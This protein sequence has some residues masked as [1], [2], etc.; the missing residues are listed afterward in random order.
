MS[1]DFLQIIL[2]Q[3]DRVFGENVTKEELS[4]SDRGEWP[5]NLWTSIEEA[6]L[7]HAMVAEAQA[8]IGLSW[9]DA[10]ALI[11]R[12][13][14]WALPLPLPETI[15]AN[16]LWCMSG[17]EAL[18]GPVA[19]GPVLHQDRIT[20]DK[21]PEGVVLQGTMH[22][23]PWLS[24]VRHLLVLAADD[25][26]EHRLCLLQAQQIAALGRRRNLACEPRENVCLDGIAVTPQNTRP[27]FA[28][29]VAPGLQPYLAAIRAQQIVGGLERSLE[30]ALNY[31]NERVQFG[32][33]IAKFQAIQHMLAVAAGQVAAATAAADALSEAPSLDDAWF[34]IA[35]AKA[36]CSEA[37]GTVAAICHQVHGAMGFTQEHPLHFTTRRLWSWRD[38]GG[39]ET[40]WQERIG[41]VVCAGGSEL[42]W[43]AIVNASAGQSPAD[44]R[45]FA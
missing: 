21:R 19:F 34:A 41:H 39:S 22:H 2:D 14:Y 24:N 18:E 4:S 31:A 27:F 1:E 30:F 38:E 3:A 43:P 6:G 25:N 37:A 42:L 13:G 5:A 11:R 26:G 45:P 33:P 29:P 28:A 15:I 7:L 44:L 10:S 16:W 32:R 12:M 35:I 8:G 20:L 40:C 36:R 9:K 23:V 17:G